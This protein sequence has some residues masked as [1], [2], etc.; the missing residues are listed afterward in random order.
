MGTR[1]AQNLN[2]VAAIIPKQCV[3]AALMTLIATTAR[4]MT[5]DIIPADVNGAVP[6]ERARTGVMSAVEKQLQRLQI[7]M[8]DMQK[9]TVQNL[10]TATV[11]KY[12]KELYTE[13]YDTT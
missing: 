11:Y 6:A 12:D 7:D 4:N 8:T 9:N 10:V 3:P 5:M 2:P 1:P 13:H